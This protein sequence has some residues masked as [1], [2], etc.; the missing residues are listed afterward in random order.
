MVHYMLYRQQASAS[1]E[2]LFRTELLLF[3]ADRLDIPKIFIG[4]A[5]EVK[6]EENLRSCD[7]KIVA[8]A[9]MHA[10][11]G[12]TDLLLA[13]MQRMESSV[14]VCDTYVVSKIE[15]QLNVNIK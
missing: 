1:T 13:A 2:R 10:C 15:H 6:A 8:D 7:S 11:D 3:P 14:M 9:T 12:G 4:T 5:E